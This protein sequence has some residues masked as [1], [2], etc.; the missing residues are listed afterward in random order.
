MKT[1]RAR[2]WPRLCQGTRHGRN[3]DHPA[4]GQRRP[5]P[6]AGVGGAVARYWLERGA[7]RGSGCARRRRR[8]CARP[9]LQTAAFPLVPYSNRI[10]AGRFT[11]RGR[12]VALPLN[13]PR[14]ATRSTGTAG[15]DLAGGRRGA[16]RSAA[17]VPS[18][19][20]RLAVGLP[21]DAAVRPHPHEPHGDAQPHQR[22]R[23]ADAGR[24]RLA[25]VLPAHGAGDDHRRRPR[26]RGSPTRR[27][28]RPRWARRRPA[29]TSRAEWRW[30]ASRS[31]TSS[32]AGA[33]AVIEWPERGAGLTMTAGAPLDYL[34]IFTPPGRP[35][36]RGA[37][38]PRDRRV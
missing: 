1:L 15:I 7:R 11:F 8:R 32:R 28:C 33:R 10:R 3:A 29:P 25:P 5:R 16:E 21:R 6:R 30:K 26:P 34:V 12:A 36:L 22:E 23:R 20:V 37:G 4:R 17:R 18:C 19:G 24:A 35:L 31:T 14:S 9:S 2:V 13:R 38:Q 27:R